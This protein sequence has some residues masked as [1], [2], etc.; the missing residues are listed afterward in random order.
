MRIAIDALA[1]PA[2]GGAKSSALGWLTALARYD[3]NNHYLAFLSRPEEALLPCA[4]VEQ[5]L[6]PVH[7][8]LAVRLWA[9][10]QLP[11]L[12]AREQ[13]D[14]LHSMKNLSVFAAPCPTIVTIN[15]LSHLILRHLYPRIDGLYW[16]LVQPQILR[17]ARR[18]IAI[19]ENTRHDLQRFYGLSAHKVVTIYPSCHDLFRQSCPLEELE[20]VRSQYVLPQS[21]LLYVGGL[22]VH[23]NVITLLR[24]FARV[25]AQIPHGLVLVG[26]AHHTSSD[27]TLSRAIEA[28]GLVGRVWMLGPVP[29]EDLVP[30]YQLA[31]LFLLA[32]LN[33]GFGLVL[34][35]AMVCGLPVLAARRG[36]VAEVVGECACLVDDPQDIEGFSRGIVTL[37]ADRQRLERMRTCGLQRSQMFTWEGTAKRTLALYEEVAH[38]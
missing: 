4:N 5:R 8:R 29:L 26:G 30:L 18:V 27:L 28:L 3:R 32:S 15:D 22:G 6:V 35:E 31:D 14:V 1:L 9:Q 12:L 38:G 2:F 20:R 37:L 23:K 21:M 11:R 16:Q 36:S 33:E 34:L 10:V 7:N 13:V 24:A 25:A 17:R 19:S